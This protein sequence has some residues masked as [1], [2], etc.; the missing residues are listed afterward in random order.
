ME[1]EPP[2]SGAAADRVT[3]MTAEL[4]RFAD[5]QNRRR[6]EFHQQL[7]ASHYRTVRA[8]LRLAV[9]TRAR[10]G[11]LTPNWRDTL[12]LRPAQQPAAA[13]FTSGEQLAVREVAATPPAAWEPHSGAGWRT[14][15]ET[16]YYAT[17]DVYTD[18]ETIWQETELAN[19]TRIIEQRTSIR[20]LRG[21]LGW[22][23]PP[24]AADPPS[25][26]AVNPHA[27]RLH[28]EVWY[29]A[30]LAAGGGPVDWIGWLRTR[31]GDEAAGVLARIEED[32]AVCRQLQYLPDY[33]ARP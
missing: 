20:R 27:H 10:A 15:L 22:P 13:M 25:A 12:A 3:Q 30:G 7:S 24:Q 6:R 31:G 26:T 14:A 5:D 17:L 16:W 8:N 1:P 2:A 32:P 19:Q 33:W 23:H 4:H 18:L 11:T 29:R 28:V 21:R 9:L